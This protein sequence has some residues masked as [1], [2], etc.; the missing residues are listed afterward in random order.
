MR[1]RTILILTIMLSIL[2]PALADVLVSV[3]CPRSVYQYEVF[4]CTVTLYNDSTLDTTLDYL[5]HFDKGRAGLLGLEKEGDINIPALTK[6]TIEFNVWARSTGREAFVFEYGRGR[7]DTLAAKAFY[8][9]APP[10]RLDLDKVSLTAGRKNVVKTRLE[11]SG[12]FVRVTFD[13]PPGIIG[14][15]A[16][17]VGDVDEE[18][19]IT[20]E[21][22]P[23]PYIMGTK[24]LDVYI[25]FTDDKGDH[26]LLQRIELSISPS[27]NVI[28]AILAVVVVL[29]LAVLV[30][31]K[32]QKESGA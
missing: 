17:D 8:I 31:R 2:G 16:I 3:D 12:S 21:M 18:A 22:S 30:T 11:G 24:T 26:L 20:V 28:F 10:L 27:M 23:D 14:T 9:S 15:T 1:L 32:R 7:I 13:Y 6:Q 29:A 25:R 4:T 19:P 5:I